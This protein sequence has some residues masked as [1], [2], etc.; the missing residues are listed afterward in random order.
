MLVLHVVVLRLSGRGPAV[1][2]VDDPE[3]PELCEGRR[4]EETAKTDIP[5]AKS[6]RK[7]ARDRYEVCST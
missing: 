1:D 3:R 5:H 6:V 7:E 2:E 4:I